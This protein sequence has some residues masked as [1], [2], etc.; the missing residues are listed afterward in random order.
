MFDGVHPDDQANA[1]TRLA[2]LLERPGASERTT[3]RRRDEHGSW[4]VMEVRATNLLDR[5]P[6]NGVL[7]NAR[8]ITEQTQLEEQLR[9][10]QRMDAIGRLAGGVAHDFNNLLTV[11]RANTEFLLEDLE[12]SD[13]RRDDAEQIREAADRAA[14][15]TRQL[16]AFS[17]KQ[18]LDPRALDVNEVVQRVQPMLQRLI[19][20]DITMETLLGEGLGT[21]TADAGQLEQV[22]LNLVVNARDAMP[23][24]GRI[25]VETS[26]VVV[27][28]AGAMVNERVVDGALSEGRYV[29]LSVTDTG[30]GMTETVRARAFEPFFTTKP[31]GRGTGLGLSTVYGIVKQSGGYVTVR[32][33]P[34]EGSTLAA[35]LPVSTAPESTTR[36]EHPA[37]EPL[38]G[39]GIVLL[40]EDEAAVRMLAKRILEHRGYTVLQAANGMEALAIAT[41]FEGTI[42]L[43]LTD[44]VMPKM[45][46]RALVEQLRRHR[47]TLS[48]V[49]MSGY[50][51]DDIVRRGIA[52]PGTGF[53]QKPF[54]SAGLLAAVREALPHRATDTSDHVDPD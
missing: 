44:V 5:A 13:R 7:V 23:D 4:R 30:S 40:A 48:V 17:R 21:V 32:S 18:I 10:S 1:K 6:L 54:T 51:D 46:G 14:A 52:S 53:V 45:S 49:Y 3:L 35:F 39:R 22:L 50:T 33:S 19:E 25:L 27:T 36:D 42:D 43:V 26:G 31:E 29:R 41:S 28:D 37:Q 24:G 38:P 47:P 15:L 12:V 9:Q 20:E 16:L 2:A 34:G 11:I 8:D